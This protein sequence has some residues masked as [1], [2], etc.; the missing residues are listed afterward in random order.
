MPDRSDRYEV[1]VIGAGQAGLAIGYYLAAHG[2]RFLIIEREDDVAPAWRGRWHSLTLFTPRL[3]DSLPGLAFPG[4]PDSYPRRDDVVAYLRDYA[5]TFDLPVRPA[6]AARSLAR[7]ERGFVIGTPAGDLA[8]DQIV[9]A[10]GAFQEPR[11][12]GFASGLADDVVQLHS[13]GY[14]NPSDLPA[15][16]T[17]VVGG[18]NTGYQIAQELA[19]SRETH[20]AIGT[21]QTSLPQRLL[22]R[23]AF[24]W[25]TKTGLI[26]KSVETRLGTKMSQ[27]ETL[28]G[29][30]PSKIKRSGVGLHARAVSAAGRTVSFADGGSLEVNGV[31]WATGFRSDYAWIDLPIVDPDGRVT[32]KRGVTSVPGLYMLGLQ[33]QYTRGSALLGFVDADASFIAERIA[34]HARALPDSAPTGQGAELTKA[35]QGD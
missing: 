10:T 15:G 14:R 24:W 22:G 32:H 2:R 33:W 34:E 27:K 20:L 9:V 17:L 11:V 13:T 1:V 31:V 5:T 18:G 29:S 25:L 6:T 4:D 28:V 16:R 12:P 19:S 35:A 26:E 3:Y 21:R 30:R 7:A 8:A 23:D